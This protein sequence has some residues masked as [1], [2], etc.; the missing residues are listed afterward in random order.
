[1]GTKLTLVVTYEVP[2]LNWTERNPDLIGYHFDPRTFLPPRNEVTTCLVF[3]PRL[4]LIYIENDKLY[5]TFL[6]GSGLQGRMMIDG[7]KVAIGPNRVVLR[8]DASSFALEK[9]IL[10]KRVSRLSVWAM[11]QNILA[12]QYTG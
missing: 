12:T 7:E 5:C 2:I 6:G 4:E 10:Q 3:I 9:F 11:C 8:V 1:M